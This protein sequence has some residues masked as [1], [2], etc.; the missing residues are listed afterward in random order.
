MSPRCH[1]LLVAFVS[2][3]I[4]LALPL[5]VNHPRCD[6]EISGC[7][8]GWFQVEGMNNQ[9]TCINNL[10][11]ECCAGRRWDIA[12]TNGVVE[13]NFVWCYGEG[14]P[15]ILDCPNQCYPNN[16]CE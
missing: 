14:N 12:C 1:G 5:R 6:L 8:P 16:S 4:A 7:P 10:Y 15:S 11:G 13:Q 3:A 2:G 9:P